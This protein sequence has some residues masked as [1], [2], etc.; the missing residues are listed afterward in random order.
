M[1]LSKKG[2]ID[3]TGMAVGGWVWSINDV[4]AAEWG[5]GM[6]VFNPVFYHPKKTKKKK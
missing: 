1:T 2:A 3:W 5:Q 4:D 6:K